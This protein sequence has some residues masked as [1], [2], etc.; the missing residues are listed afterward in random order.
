MNAPNAELF[1]SLHFRSHVG[2]NGQPVASV[3]AFE[4]P[5]CFVRLRECAIPSRAERLVTTMT[6]QAYL[7]RERFRRHLCACSTWP[8]RCCTAKQHDDLAAPDHSITSSA[9]ASTAGGISRSS[10][11]AIFMLITS[12]NL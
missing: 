4:H 3:C 10:T 12:S 11:L 7:S 5:D 8:R 1:K 9:R 2:D 6:L